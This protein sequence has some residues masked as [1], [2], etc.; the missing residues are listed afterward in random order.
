MFS[1]FSSRTSSNFIIY[2]EDYLKI[3]KLLLKSSIQLPLAV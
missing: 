3:V 2:I 1:S